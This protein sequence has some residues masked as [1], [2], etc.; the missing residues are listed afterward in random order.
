[1]SS[2]EEFVRAHW[3]QPELTDHTICCAED[4]SD[5]PYRVQI[6]LIVCK[7]AASPEGAWS[8]AAA[9]TRERLEEVRQLR[10]EVD[11]MRREW[12]T[13]SVWVDVDMTDGN[14]DVD[15]VRDLHVC[16][17]ILSRLESILADKLRGMRE[18]Q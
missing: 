14:S 5:A 7:W 15:G 12:Q 3:E 13:V 10:R 9:Y 16:S 2:D 11:Y 8:A 1:M 18:A 17:R 6:G 4:E